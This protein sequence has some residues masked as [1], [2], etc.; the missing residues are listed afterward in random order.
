MLTP[1]KSQFFFVQLLCFNNQLSITIS[2]RFSDFLAFQYLSYIR[3]IS[4][5]KEKEEDWR[6][7]VRGSI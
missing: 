1:R 2:S 6:S 3:H 5:V 7:W 4:N